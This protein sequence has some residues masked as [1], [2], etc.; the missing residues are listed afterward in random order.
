MTGSRTIKT[1]TALVI[2]MT[3]G[4]FVLILME[5]AP[6]VPNVPPL[7]A[8]WSSDAE[9]LIASTSVPLNEDWQKIVIHTAAE[10]GD[11]E[12]NCHFIV[13]GG[14]CIATSNW[15]HQRATRH[16]RPYARAH[17]WRTDVGICVRGDYSRGP[18][19]AEERESLARLIRAL[20]AKLNIDASRVL[21]HSDLN[22]RILAPSAAFR[23]EI[24]SRVPGLR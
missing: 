12:A 9:E 7:A 5:T 24:A 8:Q 11:I 16:V 1:L 10:G 2:A 3:V 20:Q 4:A 14:Q 21:F 22:D 17:D 23:R 13:D 19:P 6:I 15:K 18:L